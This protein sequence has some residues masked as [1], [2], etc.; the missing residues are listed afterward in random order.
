MGRHINIDEQLCTG[1]GLCRSVCI[2]GGIS[3][4]DG[5]AL[6]S[7]SGACFDCGQCFAVCPS[8]AITMSRFPGSV[9]E[10]M[11]V[12]GTVAD[13]DGIMG[14]LSRRRSCRLFTGEPVSDGEFELLFEAARLSPT[15]QN[16]MDVEFVVIDE[17][18]DGF[19]RMLAD[20]LEPLSVEYPRIARGSRSL[21]VGG[22]A[23]DPR[24]LQG[25]VQRLHRHVQGGDHGTGHGTRR[26]LLHVDTY[27]GRCGPSGADVVH[28][29]RRSRE[30]A[31]MRVRHRS[32]EDTLQA[33]GSQAR[34]DGAPSLNILYYNKGK[35]KVGPGGPLMGFR[36]SASAGRTC[37]PCWGS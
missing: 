25:S 22:E 27:G 24:V 5:K 34:A 33:H 23:G 35:R 18:L 2:R 20:V 26:V 31:R 10:R 29:L 7:D 3:I 1:C 11:A 8:G 28:R 32:S 17:R 36:R 14:L 37:R 19:R 15:A 13:P 9:P 21:H 4:K 16:A 30:E 12:H 6:E